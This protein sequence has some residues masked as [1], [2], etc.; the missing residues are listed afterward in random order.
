MITIRGNDIY[1]I[2]RTLWHHIISMSYYLR[3]FKQVI[4]IAGGVLEFNCYSN[5]EYESLEFELRISNIRDY[6]QFVDATKIIE[7]FLEEDLEK[8]KIYGTH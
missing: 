1:M 8:E 5:D 2:D 4:N 7:N 3:K 6:K